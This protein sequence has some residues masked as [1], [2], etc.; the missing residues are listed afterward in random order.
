[1]LV[2]MNMNPAG[3]KTMAKPMFMMLAKQIGP[4]V[5][6]PKKAMAKGLEWEM[7]MVMEMEM[8]MEI[9]LILTS[10]WFPSA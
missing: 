4:M 7:V 6:G 10:L 2:M 1:M 9:C 8:E 3:V 5:N